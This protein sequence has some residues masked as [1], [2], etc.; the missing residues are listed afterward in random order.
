MTQA[1]T[2]RFRQ[3][4]DDAGL[5]VTHQRQVIYEVLTATDGHPSPEEVYARV[6]RR[7]PSISLA[8]VYKNIHLFIDAGI[9]QQVSLH[10]GSMRVETNHS[11]HHHLVCT[12]C[13]AITDID[14][15]SLGLPPMPE[16]LP[17]GFLPQRISMD[18]LGLCPRCQSGATSQQT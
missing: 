6:K 4:C 14:A 11:A 3:V 16:K 5:A 13:K 18:V 7:I 15:A 17:G 2:A 12:E 1:E 10:H 8:T 9:F